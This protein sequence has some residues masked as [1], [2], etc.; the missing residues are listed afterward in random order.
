MIK[1]AMA[2]DHVML[3]KSLV[4]V[5]S[6]MPEIRVLYDAS[7]GQE[8]LHLLKTGPERPDICILDIN[9]PEMDGYDT[10]QQI[11]KNWP[12]MKILALSMYDTEFNIIKMIR[13]GAGGYVL[14]DCP[15]DE[16]YRAV[17]ELQEHHYCY[18]QAAS[19]QVIH[20]ALLQTSQELTENEIQFLKLCC[21]DLTYKEIA[22]KMCKSPRTIDG[23]RDDLFARLSISSRSGLVLYAFKIGLVR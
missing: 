10:A 7:N 20:K 16:L 3:R 17:T 21:S 9:M 15:P 12:E 13:S 4:K 23:Y 14:K 18:S 11:K 1:L 5:L 6:G 19:G 8:L 2:D 22:D